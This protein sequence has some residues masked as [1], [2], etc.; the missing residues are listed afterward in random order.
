MGVPVI[1]APCEAEA[2]CAELAKKKKVYATATE[3]MDALTFRTPKLVRRLTFSQGGGSKDKQQPIL[4]LDLETV[5]Q[6]LELTYEQFVDLCILCGCDYCSTIKGVGPKT[7]CSSD[8]HYRY[9]I[10]SDYQYS[11]GAKTYQA[12]Q[13]HRG[14]HCPNEEGEEVRHSPGLAPNAG[15]QDSRSHRRGTRW[16]R[17]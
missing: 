7:V 12:A 4:E 13:E 3:D 6:G 11:P 5:L 14:S 16:R 8:H 10:L 15:A 2:Q 17:K 1:T 9:H